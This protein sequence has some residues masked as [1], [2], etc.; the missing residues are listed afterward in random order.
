MYVTVY[1]WMYKC[2][3]VCMCVRI[4]VTVDNLMRQ[5]GTAGVRVGPMS[6]THTF[7]KLP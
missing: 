6:Q 5:N 2:M 4:Y 3:Y 7:G 1:A